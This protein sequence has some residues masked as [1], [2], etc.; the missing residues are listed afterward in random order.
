MAKYRPSNGSE[1]EWF[2][3]E[4]CCNCRRDANEDCPILADTFCYDVD[5]PAYPSE[6]IADEEGPRCT[7]FDDNRQPARC[8]ATADMFGDRA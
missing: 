2:I 1:G 7:A 3:A 4:F 6:W 8:A 5:D